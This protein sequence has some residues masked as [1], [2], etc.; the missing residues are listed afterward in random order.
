MGRRAI[1][2]FQVKQ[3]AYPN[4]GRTWYIVGRPG[5]KRIRAWF[6]TKL[7][8]EAEA[9]QRNLSIQR[10]GQQAATFSG[11]LAYMA[12]ECQSRL[13]PYGKSLHDATAHYL[14][15]LEGVNR[16]I[17][18]NRVTSTVRREFERRLTAGEISQRHLESM[19]LALRRLDEKF[20]QCASNLI[21]GGEIKAW[22]SKSD[23]STKTRNNL[24]GYFSNAFN[25]ARELQ[26]LTDNPLHEVRA[27]NA[28]KVSKK[29]NPRFL[30]VPQMTALLHH[31]HPSLIPYLSVCA[32]AGLRSAEAKRLSWQQVDLKR[33]LITVPENIS[34]TGEERKVPIQ[35]NL[36]AWL[37]PYAQKT[38]FILSREHCYRID[39]LLKAAKLAAG[40]WPWSPRFQNAL[41]KSF[42]SYHYEMFGSAD[43][44]SQFAGH[45]LRLLVKTYLHTVDHEEAE[46]FWAIYPG[47]A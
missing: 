19:L 36:A 37:A 17:S 29:D 2:E 16:S 24:L 14:Q 12:M 34:K 21:S 4:A 1:S 23:W 47:Q 27:F 25:V 31:A 8:A 30:T 35:P 6:D 18:L 15:H 32:F 45:S 9:T 20:G 44:T 5:G 7:I 11:S 13:Q 3:T 33:N 26:L 40:L 28:S 39:H 38:G 43:R 41:R 46:K 10:F 42:C 22:L